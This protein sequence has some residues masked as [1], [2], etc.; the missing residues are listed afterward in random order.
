MTRKVAIM[1]A[2]LLL[3]TG[4]AK[5][6]SSLGTAGI[7][8]LPDPILTITF[9]HL[10][11]IV[12]IIEIIVAL[13]CLFSQKTGLWAALVAWLASGFAAYRFGLSWIGYR[14]ACP[15][16]GTLT[17]S[18][19]ISPQIADIAMKIILVFLLIAS[20]ATLIALWRQ[21]RTSIGALGSA[22]T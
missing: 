1:C 22:T 10:F 20:Y 2:V 4:L 8:E 5:L 12:G 16:L 9:R 19:H 15:C 21:K 3:L 7:L 13:L 11:V 17:S 14:G 18:L 6:L